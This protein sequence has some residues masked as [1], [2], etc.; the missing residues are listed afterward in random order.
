M[1]YKQYDSIIIG[2]GAA[3]LFCAI[4]AAQ[5]GKSV[6]V[7]EHNNSLGKKIL[8][9]GG[10]RCNFT[11]LS[12]KS[13]DFYCENPH[14][15]K[16]ALSQYT[17]LDFIALVSTHE[18]PFYE[19][20]LG[21][22]FCE[23]SAKDILKMLVSL[24]NEKSIDLLTNTN[25]ISIEKKNVFQLKSHSEEYR[26]EDLVIATGGPA[27]SKIGASTF[28][29]EIAK[30]F[31]HEVTQIQPAL[32]PVVTNQLNDLSGISL[33]VEINSNNRI[34]RD[35]LLFTHKGMSGPATLKASLFCKKNDS[36][37]INFL[38]TINEFPAKGSIKK[39]FRNYLPKRLVDNL[40][41]S[42]TRDNFEHCSSSDMNE[43]RDLITNYDLKVMD[44]EHMDKAEATRGGVSVDDISSKTLESKL[45]ENLYFIGEVLDVTGLLGGYNFQWAWSSGWAA[46]NAISLK[47]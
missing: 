7:I 13:D 30:Q 14:F 27:V 3:G 28:G 1:S 10:G 42:Y 45:V 8:I 41:D 46:G 5:Y 29:H 40:L 24:C 6:A 47:H 2:G 44:F 36:L 4:H 11:N 35:D 15:V 39:Y 17:N 43:L 16:S 23:R 22:L 37:Y 32:V 9:S 33:K 26:C 18:I 19:K 20:K 31:G 25:I 38:P 12:V 21:Q 34:I